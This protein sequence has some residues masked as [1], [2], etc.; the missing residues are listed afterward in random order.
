MMQF[1]H[2]LFFNLKLILDKKI[3]SV[4]HIPLHPTSE[5]FNVLVHRID[6]HCK[7]VDITRL[8]TSEYHTTNYICV[9]ENIIK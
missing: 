7:I 9:Y 6:I 5:L 4:H 3:F 1:H 8:F 2:F